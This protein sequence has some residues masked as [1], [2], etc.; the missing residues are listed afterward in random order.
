M[1]EIRDQAGELCKQETDLMDENLD[2]GLLPS[3]NLQ[4]LHDVESGQHTLRVATVTGFAF[5]IV[6]TS[7]VM[8]MITR[9]FILLFPSVCCICITTIGEK[10]YIHFPQG[11]VE[12]WGGMS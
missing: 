12:P 8:C 5:S 9:L 3:Q 11:N 6:G 2:H 7:L 4:S 1:K 10:A